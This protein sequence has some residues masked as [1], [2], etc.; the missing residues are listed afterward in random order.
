MTSDC[1]VFLER[2]FFQTL[3]T[4][5]QLTSPEPLTKPATDKTLDTEESNTLDAE[6]PGPSGTTTRPLCS[7]SVPSGQPFVE[8]D[9][10]DHLQSVQPLHQCLI[11]LKLLLVLV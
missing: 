2:S 7:V 9:D 3:C 10:D 8:I 6:E 4:H 11:F 1:Y 5:L